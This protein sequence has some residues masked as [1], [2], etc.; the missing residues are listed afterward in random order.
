VD[1][2]GVGLTIP[3]EPQAV[4]A[5]GAAILAQKFRADIDGIENIKR[6]NI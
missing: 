4:G 1:N 3:P 6:E 5:V 2:L